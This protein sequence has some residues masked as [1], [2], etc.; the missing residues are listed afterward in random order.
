MS[1]K[2]DFLG[3]VSAFETNFKNSLSILLT[4]NNVNCRLVFLLESLVEK[5]ELFA[6]LPVLLGFTKFTETDRVLSLSEKQP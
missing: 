1:T 2:N 6:Q 3:P 4:N 5:L